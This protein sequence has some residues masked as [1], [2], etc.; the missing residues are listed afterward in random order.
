VATF[1][2][3]TDGNRHCCTNVRNAW[4][5]VLLRYPGEIGWIRADNCRKSRWNDDF[6]LNSRASRKFG[7]VVDPS[8]V[9]A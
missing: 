8:G 4:R 3:K 1:P 9:L 6:G 2:I 7:I 5:F